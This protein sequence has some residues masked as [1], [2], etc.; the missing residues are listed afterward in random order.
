MTDKVR[1]AVVVVHG[2]GEQRPLDTINTF[3]EAGLAPDKDGERLFHSR[4]DIVTESYDSRRY[5]APRRTTD[6]GGE[7]NAQTEFFE[8]HWSYQMQGNRIDDMVPT[9]KRM[10]L[11]PPWRVP[12]G[13]RVVWALF[14]ILLI[15]VAVALWS[16]SFAVDLRDF[17]TERLI[18]T[19]VG[20]GLIGGIAAYAITKLVPRWVTRSFVD[21]ARYLDTSPR[22]FEIRSKIREGMVDLL[23]GLHG[24]KLSDGSRRYDRIVIV[25]HS[26]GA[27][28]AYDG[29]T[30]LWAQLNKRHSGPGQPEIP[31]GLRDLEEAAS[32][33]SKE[34]SEVNIDRFQAAQG[35]LWKG[36]RAQGSPW[37]ITD[38]ISV[39][40]PMYFADRLY[41]KNE[42]DFR[43]RVRK[44]ELATCP[45]QSE[46][47][48]YNNI[49]DTDLWYTWKHR[50]RRVL[51]HGA[52][53]AVVRW[54][55]MWFPSVFGFFG[56]WFGGPLRP[57]YGNGV[58]DM[59]L[60]E[61]KPMRLIPG[62]AH[63]IY[64]TMTGTEP[65]VPGSVISELRKAMALA[66]TDW[67]KAP[68]VQP[69]PGAP[70]GGVDAPTKAPG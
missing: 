13:L 11:Q 48:S 51:Y 9:L 68:V 23:D 17:T 55:N 29:I 38:F 40:T 31:H 1:Q 35:E 59:R 22:S 12:S 34:P 52:P 3:I 24:A 21:V 53:F 64:F 45:P 7:L 65:P 56:D 28:I 8:Y 58:R 10:L 19:I 16:G 20:T 30:A 42:T 60:T 43:D 26:L 67:M 5:L 36:M 37:L 39:G 57:L 62:Y 61:D 32:A 54:T 70:T 2:M 50:G 49:H 4:P 66:S 6:A 18:R 25:A 46:G 27:Y 15:Y 63:A 47:A 41:T 14:W 44:R 33:V 69:N